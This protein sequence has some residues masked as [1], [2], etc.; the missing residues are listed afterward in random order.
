M[1]ILHMKNAQS[2]MNLEIDLFDHVYD[3][4]ILYTQ[5]RGKSRNK[6]EK[7]FENSTVFKTIFT[8]TTISFWSE[9]KRRLIWPKRN[10][11]VRYSQICTGRFLSKLKKK[12]K[13]LP[14]TREFID[15]G[16][17]RVPL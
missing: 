5:N 3:Y 17:R 16:Y 1:L 6:R 10:N 4:V 8:N 15:R 2:F 11:F 9:I 12:K 13:N 7:T 14:C